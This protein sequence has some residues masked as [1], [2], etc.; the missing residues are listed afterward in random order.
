VRLGAYQVD[1]LFQANE[2]CPELSLLMALDL[3]P[4]TF[5]ITR[6]HQLFEDDFC[7]PGR[8]NDDVS[9]QPTNSIG[10]NLPASASAASGCGQC[11][12]GIGNEI[13]GKARGDG[14]K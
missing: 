7:V 9:P 3:F 1:K 11:T 10:L 12:G 8:V 14:E 4:L 5:I 13:G 2:S 6:P